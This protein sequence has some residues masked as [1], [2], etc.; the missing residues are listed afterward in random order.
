[1]DAP[2]A[3]ETVRLKDK[4]EHKTS[5]EGFDFRGWDCETGWLFTCP[6][7]PVDPD[8]AV[9]AKDLDNLYIVPRMPPGHEVL[10]VEPQD[11]E[12]SEKEKHAIRRALWHWE[13][14]EPMSKTGTC[15]LQ[16][17]TK[18][19]DLPAG[20]LTE[21]FVAAFANPQDKH[22]VIKVLELNG[23]QIT[24]YEAIGLCPNR[25]RLVTLHRMADPNDGHM[26]LVYEDNETVFD[27]SGKFK[28]I[29]HFIC[30]SS[31]GYKVDGV[32]V[33]EKTKPTPDSKKL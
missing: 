33:I 9:W 19:L 1:M 25:R 23:Y 18:A 12:F 31:W 30:A 27:S 3:Y 6:Q 22:D 15:V 4:E 8:K 2:R 29:A 14:E 7:L 5:F 20:D 17:L 16:C 21:M 26:I 24:E 10:T 13:F 28:K 32:L 11:A